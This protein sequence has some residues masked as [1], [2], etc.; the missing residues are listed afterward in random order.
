MQPFDPPEATNAIARVSLNFNKRL[1]WT[2]GL[3][4]LGVSQ[5]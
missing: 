5:A 1:A 4:G 2:L 3:C